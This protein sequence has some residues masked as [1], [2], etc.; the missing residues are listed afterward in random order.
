MLRH[1]AD[2]MGYAFSQVDCLAHFSMVKLQSLIGKQLPEKS[3]LPQV[4]ELLN[5]DQF[6]M[7]LE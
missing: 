4:V 6:N 3:S 2:S 5:F 7:L 1:V